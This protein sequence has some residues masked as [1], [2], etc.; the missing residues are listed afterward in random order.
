MEPVSLGAAHA[1]FSNSRTAGGVPLP[2]SIVAYA[3][4]SH[5]PRHVCGGWNSAV[6]DQLDAIRGHEWRYSSDPCEI[7]SGNSIASN[8]ILGGCRPKLRLRIL[9]RC[10]R[11][12]GVSNLR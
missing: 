7:R 5:L 8:R 6:C 12:M 4:T 9:V 10:L 11:R 3:H 2:Q 1:D